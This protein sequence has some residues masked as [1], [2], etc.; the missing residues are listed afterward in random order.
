MALDQATIERARALARRGMPS[1]GRALFSSPRK[2]Y[3]PC[4]IRH[5]L[6]VMRHADVRR[7]QGNACKGVHSRGHGIVEQERKRNIRER[8][9]RHSGTRGTLASRRSFGRPLINLRRQ[10]AARRLLRAD[11]LARTLK[12]PARANSVTDSHGFACRHQ[13]R[14][15]KAEAGTAMKCR[16]RRSKNQ[17]CRQHAALIAPITGFADSM[18]D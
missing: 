5:A 18:R 14:C 6:F 16:S 15:D 10:N 11:G 1:A 13:K 7:S 3:S 9:L 17:E 12:E 4:T 2:H 8:V